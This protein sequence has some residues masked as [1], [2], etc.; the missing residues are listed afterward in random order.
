MTPNDLSR[1]VANRLINA[2][3]PEFSGSVVSV[4]GGLRMG[5]EFPDVP[6]SAD[7]VV[8]VTA[9]DIAQPETS[10]LHVLRSRTDAVIN[11]WAAYLQEP[12]DQ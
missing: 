12:L 11:R 4:D 7:D 3:F 2:G 5:L 1:F 10:R 6:K 8:W 9:E